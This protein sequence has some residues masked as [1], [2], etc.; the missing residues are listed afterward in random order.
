MLCQDCHKNLATVRYA[1]VVD[2]NV[3]ERHLC[4]ECLAR[5]QE[6][7]DRGF[8]L[9]GPPPS[10]KNTPDVR[11][12]RN[13]EAFLR[14]CP[15]CST[16]F[17]DVCRTGVVGCPVCYETFSEQL[18]SLLGG[19]QP[20]PRHRGKTPR[21]DDARARLRGDLQTKRA[22]LRRSLDTENYEE[23]AI[24]R[25]EIKGLEAKLN[26]PRPA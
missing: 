11:L 22:L 1:E 24:L 17:F 2:G 16:R 18:E 8:R 14:T 26:E 5:H 23:A 10:L 19:Q 4:Q 7:D 15:V 12:I 13:K 9:S 6:A 25:D 20:L 3:T 21:V